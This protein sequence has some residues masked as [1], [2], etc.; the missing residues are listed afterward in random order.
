MRV[1]LA[2]CSTAHQPRPAA[3]P[4]GIHMWAAPQADVLCPGH[5]NNVQQKCLVDQPHVDARQASRAS[6]GDHRT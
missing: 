3:R 6:R 1:C 2:K 4:Y 5:A